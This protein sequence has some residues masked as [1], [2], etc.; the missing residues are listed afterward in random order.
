MAIPAGDQLRIVERI[1]LNE[2]T[3]QLEIE[4]TMT[5][6][7]HWVGEWVHTKYFNRVTDA[8]IAEATCRPD[9]N[10]NMLST[11]SGGLVD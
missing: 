8:D 2:E 5:D 7:E 10:D 11:R 6:P 9:L 4:Y 3:D 1:R